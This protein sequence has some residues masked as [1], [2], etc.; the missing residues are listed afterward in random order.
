MRE[1]T[2]RPENRAKRLKWSENYRR[3]PKKWAKQRI[4]Q[5]RCKCRK[6]GMELT[7]TEDDLVLPDVCP[8][9]GIPLVIGQGG[10]PNPN[11]ASVDRLDNSKGYTPDNVRVISLRANQLKRDATLE[12]LQAVVRYMTEELETKKAA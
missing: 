5:I 12:E 9:L 4:C 6:I 11:L 7:I 8:V 10:M 2:Q 3:D 1:Y